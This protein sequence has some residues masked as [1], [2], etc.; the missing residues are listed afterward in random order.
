MGHGFGKYLQG[1]DYFFAPRP[2]KLQVLGNATLIMTTKKGI[3]VY[4]T[5]EIP[6]PGF[7]RDNLLA[8]GTQ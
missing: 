1:L 3:K 8:P 2:T 5:Y 6:I 4:Y 7:Q